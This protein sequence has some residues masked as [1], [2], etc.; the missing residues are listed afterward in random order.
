M[1]SILITGAT[2]SFGNAFVR[3]L[4]DKSDYDRIVIYSRDELKQS[5]MRAALI[6]HDTRLRFLIGDVRDG[7]RLYRAMHGV[8]TVV[9]AAALKQ[10]P[11]CEYN[12]LEAVQTNVIGVV[13]AINAAIE[14]GVE[15]VVAL[16]SDKA[17][18][19]CTLYGMTK[20]V[21]ERL[22][23]QANVYSHY[24]RFACVR[25]GNVWN[26]RGS[27]VEVWKKQAQTGTIDLTDPSAT[28]FFLT[29]HDACLLVW[30]ALH[31]MTGGE[32]FIPNPIS[33][34]V[35]T[36]A[37]LLHPDCDA[38]IIGLRQGEKMHE[39]L[40]SHDEASRTI[41]Q[42]LNYIIKPA[43]QEWAGGEIAGDPMDADFQFTSNDAPLSVERGQEWL[44]E[45]SL[46]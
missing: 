28:R 15:R 23:V 29:L 40:I 11:A 6:E 30:V 44:I 21:A 12:P 3:F 5:V 37:L 46:L 39:L 32:T 8:E 14:A 38:R 22:F 7:E 19:P 36:L 27:V 17:C 41:R 31:E 42:G 2:G 13:N 18:Q 45:K 34:T 10:V 35:R 24:T 16:S 33:M 20:A 25:Y 1:T 4:L 43:A 9:H 26:S